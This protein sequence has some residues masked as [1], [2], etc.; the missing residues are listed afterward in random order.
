MSKSR[1]TLLIF[2]LVG[3][4]QTLSVGCSSSLL[5]TR[6]NI[7]LMT[8]PT[9]NNYP[10]TNLSLNRRGWVIPD[11]QLFTLSRTGSVKQKDS[12]GALHDVYYEMF[13]PKNKLVVTEPSDYADADSKE[14]QI[15]SM[16]R[17]TI[18]G[19]IFAYSFTGTLVSTKNDQTSLADSGS[20]VSIV[21]IDGNGKGVFE[22]NKGHNYSIPSWVFI[23]S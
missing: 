4:L 19:R 2:L 10:N 17:L 7:G 3:S 16:S 12:D 5:S 6:S 13:E 21:V 14:I 8:D 20:G 11:L 23:K 22:E 1:K 9:P 18:N 15:R